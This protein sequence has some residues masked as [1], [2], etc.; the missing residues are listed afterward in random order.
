ME[1]LDYFLETVAFGRNENNLCFEVIYEVNPKDTKVIK[2]LTKV[3]K[4]LMDMYFG[5][6]TI[7]DHIKAG[8]K[9]GQLSKKTLDL[10]FLAIQDDIEDSMVWLECEYDNITL[11][12]H[13]IEKKQH[14]Y[15]EL[16]TL[17]EK[18]TN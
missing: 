17:R 11:M 12:R 18:Y 7:K 4:T 14:Y 1:V 2:V 6:L 9:F 10:M 16:L 8:T 5:I 15:Y 13:R 3:N